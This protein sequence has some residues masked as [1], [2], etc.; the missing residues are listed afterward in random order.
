MT[1]GDEELSTKLIIASIEVLRQKLDKRAQQQF[2]ART[3]LTG[4]RR[5]SIE[6]GGVDNAMK[7]LRCDVSTKCTCIRTF[8]AEYVTLS[9]HCFAETRPCRHLFPPKLEGPLPIA[10]DVPARHSHD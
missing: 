6:K 10:F 8:L 2:R 4:L 7:H 5:L 1:R 3:V 9:M